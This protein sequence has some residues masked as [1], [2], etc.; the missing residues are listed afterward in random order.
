MHICT[1]VCTGG[2]RQGIGKGIER[3]MWLVI[4]PSVSP[5][6]GGRAEPGR[7]SSGLTKARLPTSK[8]WGPARKQ[9]AG[10]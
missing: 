5:G 6:P 2:V 1:R 3:P 8:V 7:R 4:S 10:S 9:E